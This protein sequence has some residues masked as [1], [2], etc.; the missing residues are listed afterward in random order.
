[1]WLNVQGTPKLEFWACLR[2]IQNGSQRKVLKHI[3]FFIDLKKLK[4][5]Y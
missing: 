4:V 1:M 2:Q 5:E 3:M